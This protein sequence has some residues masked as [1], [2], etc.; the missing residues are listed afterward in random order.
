MWSVLLHYKFIEIV[1]ES[2]KVVVAVIDEQLEGADCVSGSVAAFYLFAHV[3]D[4]ILQL[5]VGLLAVLGNNLSLQAFVSFGSNLNSASI[6]PYRTF[7][8]K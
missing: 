3:A 2:Q 6:I 1:I 4:G 7:I 8:S 5:L